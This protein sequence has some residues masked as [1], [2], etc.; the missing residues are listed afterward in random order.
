[1]R[2]RIPLVYFLGLVLGRYLA[3][4]PVF[5]VGD[6]QRQLTF[7]IQ[8]DDAAVVDFEQPMPTLAPIAD[9]IGEERRRYATRELEVRLHQRSF[10][11]RVPDTASPICG[12]W[13][14]NDACL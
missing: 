2:R 14:R 8:V 12:S 13:E 5:V 6:D 11:E 4:W 10:R 7:T 1:M 9:Q 3:A